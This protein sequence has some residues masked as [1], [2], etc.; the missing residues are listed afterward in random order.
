MHVP[1]G[2]KYKHIIIT[3]LHVVRLE[4]VLQKYTIITKSHRI[5]FIRDDKMSLFQKIHSI[6]HNRHDVNM[7]IYTNTTR[8][9]K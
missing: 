9:S 3:D 4:K 7:C 2:I 8:E 6:A 1:S 5:Y